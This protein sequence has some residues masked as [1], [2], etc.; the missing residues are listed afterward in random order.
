MQS[1]QLNDAMNGEKIIIFKSHK[2]SGTK[3]VN[4]GRQTAFKHQ[5]AS[6]DDKLVAQRAFGSPLKHDLYQK[7]LVIIWPG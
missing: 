1:S 4:L 6:D 5:K 7:C 2:V 3:D